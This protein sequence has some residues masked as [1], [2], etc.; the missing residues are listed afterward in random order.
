MEIIMFILTLAGTIATI[1]STII[2]IRA[3]NEVKHIL[4]NIRQE[5]N[6]ISIAGDTNA[7]NEGTNYGKIIGANSGVVNGDRYGK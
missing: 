2:A 6:E 7:I 3:K 5:N 1:I 4:K